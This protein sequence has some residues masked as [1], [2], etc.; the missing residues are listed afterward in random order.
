MSIWTQSYLSFLICVDAVSHYLVQGRSP[1]NQRSRGDHP[2]ARSAAGDRP[3]SAVRR[4]AVPVYSSQ[5]GRNLRA[6]SQAAGV[7]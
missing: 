3:H 5:R 1:S 6:L 7:R 4:R 2:E